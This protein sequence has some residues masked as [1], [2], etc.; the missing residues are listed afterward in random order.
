MHVKPLCVPKHYKY[1]VAPCNNLEF[2][3][4]GQD[5]GGCEVFGSAK[6]AKFHAWS[7]YM[8]QK[9][10]ELAETDTGT[11]LMQWLE[12]IGLSHV[13]EDNAVQSF[14]LKSQTAN[15]EW[16]DKTKSGTVT[17]VTANP[18][19]LSVHRVV[20]FGGGYVFQNQVVDFGGSNTV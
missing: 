17:K 14:L 5:Q 18:P 12:T 1:F 19:I 16:C 3:F 8:A 13:V 20:Q 2:K 4:E 10:R 6:S 11:L 9:L 15:W 7:D